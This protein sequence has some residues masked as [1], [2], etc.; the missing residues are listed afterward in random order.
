M[1]SRRRFGAALFQALHM[2]TGLDGDVMEA[3][4]RRAGAEGGTLLEL[5][6]L[7]PDLTAALGVDRGSVMAAIQRLA[8]TKRIAVQVRGQK[9]YLRIFGVTPLTMIMDGITMPTGDPP[10]GG[11][12]D[13]GGDTTS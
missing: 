3:I 2:P 1:A 4:R 8:I 12:D 6:A 7:L 5:D 13:S 11:T 10:S 9:R